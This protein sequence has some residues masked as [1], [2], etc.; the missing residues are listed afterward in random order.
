[1]KM[2]LALSVATLLGARAL[3]GRF[4][5]GHDDRIFIQVDEAYLD[6]AQSASHGAWCD[7]MDVIDAVNGE[8]AGTATGN[9]I[10]RMTPQE[11]AESLREIAAQIEEAEAE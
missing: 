9:Y 7:L 1:M 11:A 8:T 3:F 6:R 4:A 5:E 2:I 10:E